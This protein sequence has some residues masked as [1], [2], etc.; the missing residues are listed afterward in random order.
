MPRQGNKRKAESQSGQRK[1]AN[2]IPSRNNIDGPGVWAT[3]DKGREKNAV[4]ELYDLFEAIADELWPP[5]QALQGHGSDLDDDDLEHQVL[6][7]VEA[8]KRPRLEKRFANCH[9]GTPCVIFISCKP[10]VDPVKLVIHHLENVERTGVTRT[11]HVL[12]LAP[13]SA[14]C[15]ASTPEI[16]VLAQK[17]IPSAFASLPEKPDG[18]RK[19]RYKLELTFRYHDKIKKPELIPLLANCV[20]SDVGHSADLEHPEIVIFV[21]VLKTVC[22]ISVVQHYERFKRFNVVQVGE[23]ARRGH[24]LPIVVGIADPNVSDGVS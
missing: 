19:Y 13:V 1:R 22:G 3:C 20:P 8:L 17:L 16:L 21:Q 24:E 11:K 7:E 10:P 5:S 12:R 9:T 6:R 15:V 2:H 4:G 18:S 23:M 14:S